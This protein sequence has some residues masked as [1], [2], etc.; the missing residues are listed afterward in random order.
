VFRDKVNTYHSERTK[1]VFT[2]AHGF[3]QNAKQNKLQNIFG[4][5]Y[6]MITLIIGAACFCAGA[7]FGIFWMAALSLAKQAD[8]DMEAQEM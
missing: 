8:E 1:S 7:L 2:F 3:L 6:L 4:K 5:D